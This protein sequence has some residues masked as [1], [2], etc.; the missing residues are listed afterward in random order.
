MKMKKI[1]LC[2][3]SVLVFAS[4]SNDRLNPNEHSSTMDMDESIHF[5]SKISSRRPLTSR[6]AVPT[7]IIQNQYGQPV[8]NAQV[9]IGSAEGFPFKNNFKVS[10]KNGEIQN[11]NEWVTNEHITADAPGFIRQTLL[12]QDPG[13]IIIKLN[14]A[15][16]VTT[17]TISG[18]VT[19]LPVVDGDKNVDFGL[20][21]AAMTRSD[22]L[23]F[24]LNSVM[25]PIND[26]M[27]VAGYEVPVPTNVSLPK[28]SETY[29]LNLNNE[30]PEYRFFTPSTSPRRLYAAAGRF[31]FKQVVDELRGG[32]P[33]YEVINYFEING[34]GIRDVTPT[35]KVTKMDIPGNELKFTQNI[36]VA[37][38]IL[39]V[40][41]V[42]VGISASEV[43]GFLIPTGIKNMKS[44]TTTALK[45][46]ANRPAFTVN[47]IK[48]Q[49]EFMKSTPGA[50]RLSASLLPYVAN[51]KPNMLPLVNDPAVTQSNGYKVALP[52][53]PS[54]AGVFALGVNM[55]ISDIETSGT[56]EKPTTT[57]IRKW[58]VL[59]LKWPQQIQMPNWPLATKSKKRFEINYVGSL[60]DQ[61]LDLGDAL[62]K[63]ATHVTHSSADF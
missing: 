39:N 1:F 45:S 63:A 20:V 41:E 50:D 42:F 11:L 19:N 12:S 34:G 17:S 24:D 38:P 30:K 61:N 54:A 32:K 35:N 28:Q 62:I 37:S 47:I 36:S 13:N 56:P 7:I 55:V 25:S 53:A 44:N 46:L 26:I 14:R 52:N 48:R 9:L 10:D 3:V 60:Q 59:G 57:L 6:N 8:P 16:L 29:F 27:K 5:S 2:S 40:D 43:S 23:N 51:K 15:A 49:N 31:P 21:M 4:C 18:Q 22:L 33:F 58:E